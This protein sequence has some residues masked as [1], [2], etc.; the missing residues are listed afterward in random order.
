VRNS[1]NNNNNNNIIEKMEES[2]EG[3]K[4]EGFDSVVV[5][6]VVLDWKE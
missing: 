3:E 4:R 1:N 2:T 6:R 5:Y